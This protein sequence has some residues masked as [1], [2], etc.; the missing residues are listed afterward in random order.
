[1]IWAVGSLR[2]LEIRVVIVCIVLLFS[3]CGLCEQFVAYSSVAPN[4]RV[5]ATVL[6]QGCGATTPDFTLVE[7]RSRYRWLGFDETTIFS[8]KYEQ[9]IQLIWA[10]SN[11][12]MVNCRTCSGASDAKFKTQWKEVEIQVVLGNT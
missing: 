11:R 5:V 6:V 3:G 1:M 2:L 4:N 8:A 9:H 12:L 7:I 10:G